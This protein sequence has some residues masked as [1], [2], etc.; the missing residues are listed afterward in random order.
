M[1]RWMDGWTDVS[2][3]VRIDGWMKEGRN[4]GWE[5]KYYYKQKMTFQSNIVFL[6]S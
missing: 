1:D 6:Y 4:Y 5:G 2:M 3:D